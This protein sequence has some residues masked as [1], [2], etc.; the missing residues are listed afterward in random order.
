MNLTI[1]HVDNAN[2]QPE[3]EADHDA[4]CPVQVSPE[5]RWK[6]SGGTMATVIARDCTR[7]RNVAPHGAVSDRVAPTDT[8]A[9]C[10]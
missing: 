1:L 10:V 2:F 7:V 5:L 8:K 9:A 4:L 3:R 6:G